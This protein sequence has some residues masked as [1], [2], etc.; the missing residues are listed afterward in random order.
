MAVQV[1]GFQLRMARAYLGFSAREL[2]EECGLSPNT[3]AN[4]EATG[5]G[6]YDTLVRLL[7]Y[8]EEAGVVFSIEDDYAW[9]GVPLEA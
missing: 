1:T 9:V 2:A 7:T 6:R 8:F 3:I 5:R 4:I